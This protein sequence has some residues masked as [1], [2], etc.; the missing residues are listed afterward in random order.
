MR[1]PVSCTLPF[2]SLAERLSPAVI[3]HHAALSDDAHTHIHSQGLRQ[4]KQSNFLPWLRRG[5]LGANHDCG[6]SHAGHLP[7]TRC[8]AA[9]EA[10]TLPAVQQHPARRLLRRQNTAALNACFLQ[11]LQPDSV[12][13]IERSAGR[14]QVQGD[15]RRKVT[16]RYPSHGAQRHA[17]ATRK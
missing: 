1:V 15:E 6:R 10:H 4:E 12:R 5:P 14:L 9:A 17:S 7:Q 11:S 16:H 13:Q 3:H 8:A 2:C